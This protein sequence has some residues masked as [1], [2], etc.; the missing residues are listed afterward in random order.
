MGLVN[1]LDEAG[2]TGPTHYKGL[3]TLLAVPGVAPF[4]YGK[5]QT[6]PGGKMATSRCWTSR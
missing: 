4:C 2:H 5:A 1:L 3:G 6:R